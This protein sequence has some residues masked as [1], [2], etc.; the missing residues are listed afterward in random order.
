LPPAFST[1]LVTTAVLYSSFA[2]SP[3]ITLSL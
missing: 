1:S 3:F 2:T